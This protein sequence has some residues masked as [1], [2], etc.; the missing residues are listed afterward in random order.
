MHHFQKVALAFWVSSLKLLPKPVITRAKGIP[1]SPL[2]QSKQVI[3]KLGKISVRMSLSGKIYCVL[4][5]VACYTVSDEFTS[6]ILFSAILVSLEDENEEEYNTIL[7]AYILPI[8]TS[9]N[10]HNTCL[11]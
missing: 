3:L 2:S 4:V 11:Q 5:M 9:G 7:R 10:V 6:F 8:E 1:A